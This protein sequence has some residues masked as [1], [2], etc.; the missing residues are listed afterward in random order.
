MVRTLGQA[1][2][3]AGLLA[4]ASGARA[5]TNADCGARL[6]P[7]SAAMASATRSL[8]EADLIDLRDVGVDGSDHPIGLSPD[9]RHLAF[10]IR[11]ASAETNTYC[12]GI[13]AVDLSAPYHSRLVDSGG[14]L[15]LGRAGQ[16]GG[17]TD[18]SVGYPAASDPKWSP[19]GRHIAYIRRDDGPSQAWLVNADGTDAHKLTRSAID[20]EDIWW[21]PSGRLLFSSRPGLARAQ[22]IIVDEQ[23]VGYHYDD[24]WQP[25][26]GARPLTI[27]HEA[28]LLLSI[29]PR[30]GL[31]GPATAEDRRIAGL[32]SELPT[33]AHAKLVAHGN[34]GDIA[35]TAPKDPDDLVSPDELHVRYRGHALACPD[36]VCGG[37]FLGF[38][39]APDHR[40]L[41]ILKRT[42][43]AL[44][45]TALFR[46]HP[47]RFRADRLFVSDALVSG[48]ELAQQNLICLSE[49]AL[50]PA[51]IVAINIDSGSVSKIFEPNPD[52]ASIRLGQVQRLTWKNDIGLE[53]FGDLVLPPDHR[54]GDRHPMIVVQ[55]TSRGF[56]R[57]GTGDAYPIQIYARA[58]FAVLS[59]QRPKLFAT[60]YPEHSN[61][62]V[63]RRQMED[64]KDARS[65]VSSIETGVARAIATGTVDPERV[66]LTGLSDGAVKARY[67]ALHTN[68]FKAV[69]IS[70]CCD[71]PTSVSLLGPFA[72][73]IDIEAGY[74]RI[75]ES[76]PAFWRPISIM[77]NLATFDTPLLIQTADREYLRSVATVEA[78]REASKAADLFVFP[79]EYHAFWQPAHKLASY[80]RSLDWFNFW[81]RDRLPDPANLQRRADANRWTVMRQQR[82]RST[83]DTSS[84]ERAQAS[85]SA[86]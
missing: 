38:W 30:T 81:L 31:V 6:A 46:W 2:L 18:F 53:A 74:P 50:H 22:S 64:A 42:G 10:Q 23:A 35:W 47:T 61:A 67:A 52:F 66:G 44:S 54:P 77:D 16:S 79:D 37:T 71:D 1:A 76:A 70:S 51:A 17:V 3:L 24:R 58:G 39:W 49:D 63:I 83:S 25:A 55:Y 69:A 84:Q 36:P 9:H 72:A 48:C 7:P 62:D 73:D 68:L 65:A 8:T 11:R 75:G 41:L 60:L 21:S 28:P 20:V 43:W 56:L 5:E 34:S 59:L 33:S 26:A 80:R 86:S 29:D 78:L 19:D 15:I 14:R 12:L 57:G 4:L 32:E 82:T 27:D 85:A 13:V 40:T 45:Q